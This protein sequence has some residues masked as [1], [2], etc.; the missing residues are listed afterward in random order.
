MILTFQT[1]TTLY[2]CLRLNAAKVAFPC[3]YISKQY[4]RIKLQHFM[5]IYRSRLQLGG[6]FT[7]F[8]NRVIKL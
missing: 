1:T 5:I 6:I 2:V 8:S 4:T 3:A 7:P